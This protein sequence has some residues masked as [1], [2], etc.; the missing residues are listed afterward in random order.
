MST[1]VDR[2]PLRKSQR[3]ALAELVERVGARRL[4][5]LIGGIGE[6]ELM[7]VAAGDVAPTLSDRAR[8]IEHLVRNQL[9]GRWIGDRSDPHGPGR[10]GFEQIGSARDQRQFERATADGHQRAA[11]TWQDPA[12][13]HAGRHRSA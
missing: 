12:R 4:T 3:L 6:P 1:P 8:I 5:R 13:M 11:S 10:E 7:V 9:A 2:F